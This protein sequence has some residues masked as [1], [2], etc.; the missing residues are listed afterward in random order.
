MYLEKFKSGKNTYIRLVECY[1]DPNTKTNRKKVIKNYGNYEKLVKQSPELLREL[2]EKYSNVKAKESQ[3]R[4]DNFER[5]VNSLSAGAGDSE[6]SLLLNYS[7]LILN[8]IWRDI[9]GMT[10]F[11]R[12]LKTRND[13]DIQ[14]DASKLTYYL[15]LQKMVEPQSHFHA[16]SSLSSYIGTGITE[17]ELSSVYRCLDYLY[18]NKESILAHINRKVEGQYPRQNSLLFYDTTNCYFET[19]LDDEQ[20][21]TRY[22]RQDF[23]ELI[24]EEGYEIKPN[25]VDALLEKEPSLIEIYQK[26]REEY[27]DALRMRGLSKELRYDLPMVSVA[28]V[29]DSNA[30]PVDFMV[31]AGNKSEKTNMIN[32]IDRL[33]SNY[34]I[35]ES[36]IVA[37]SGLN[38]V[39]N[40]HMLLKN[41][42]GYAISKSALSLP[43]KMEADITDLSKYTEK[44]DIH[45]N[46]L[47]Y[48]YRIIDYPQKYKIIDDEHPD[49][50]PVTIEIKNKMLLTFSKK[51]QQHDLAVLEEKFGKARKAVAERAKIKTANKGFSSFL[52][53]DID[54]KKL[55]AKKIKMKLIEK[56]RK[57]AGFATVIYHDVPTKEEQSW[58]QSPKE[59]TKP[60]QGIVGRKGLDNVDMSNVY[61]HLVQIERCFRIMKSNFSIRP[62][63]VRTEAHINAHVL[64]CI[65]SLIMLRLLQKK[66]EENGIHLSENAI[67]SGLND[68]RLSY[69]VRNNINVYEKLTIRRLDVSTTGKVNGYKMNVTDMLTEVIDGGKLNHYNSDEDLRKL[70][71]VK[72]LELFTPNSSE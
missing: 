64:I 22:A 21:F 62:M 26:C 20:T 23:C 55:V 7:G 24:K 56:H 38:S 68:A 47:N 25:E 19:P 10:E 69:T 61:H 34:N 31:F 72:N 33:K 45:G 36:I 48:M 6:E 40:M 43:K 53:A 52:S 14:F 32:S 9:L 57:R 27:G 51:R 1:R 49:K 3:A 65:I 42:F 16:Y 28:L 44:V 71:G 30:F 54:T 18:A 29:I 5:L 2:E 35:T 39:P 11:F 8:P 67:C 66:L 59:E 4:N 58:L 50:E 15:A 60:E 46:S 17:L 41:G 63:F 70:F 13:T 12:Y 37:D